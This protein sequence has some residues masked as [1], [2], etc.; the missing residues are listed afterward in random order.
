M[1]DAGDA[2]VHCMINDTERDN[3]WAAN[4][5]FTSSFPDTRRG[6]IKARHPPTQVA[7][8]WSED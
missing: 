5:R 7:P 1:S 4:E 2:S 6:T 8:N 3:S